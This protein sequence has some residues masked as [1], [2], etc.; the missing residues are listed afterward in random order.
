MKTMSVR[1]RAER[2]AAALR[3]RCANS[4][5]TAGFTLVELIVVIAILGI[6]AG[7]GT[8]AYSGYVKKANQAADNML[9]SAVN[10]SF[11]AACL[12]NGTDV[13]NVANA[14]LDMSGKSVAG[15]ASISGTGINAADVGQYSASF[16]KYFAGNETSEFRVIEALVF[17]AEKHVFVDMATAGE[18]TVSYGGGVVKL[19]SADIKA[20]GESTFITKVGVNDLL[21]QVDQVATFAGALTSTAM[22]QVFQSQEFMQ[23]AAEA[24]SM[25]LTGDTAADMAAFNAKLVELAGTD[26]DAQNKVLSNAAVMFAA[27][28]AASM[29]QSEIIDLLSGENARDTIIGNLSGNTGTALT[30]AA[31]AY[32]MYMAYAHDSGDSDKINN[33]DDPLAVMNAF[34]TDA[35]FK[36]YVASDKGKTDLNG[37]LS[38]LRMLDNSTED[39]AAVST[40]LVKGFNDPDL[41]N[42]FNQVLSDR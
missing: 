19:N 25:T 13:Q 9:L 42:L 18:V 31:L 35:D 6:L 21:D 32:G 34:D 1:N 37:Y 22:Q 27:H 41:V 40:V 2:I 20:L 39:S 38:A 8:V 15:V 33:V 4:T 23:Y 30:Q 10:T 16:V 28:N 12:E 3:E 26:P 7:V 29:P 14:A 36:S 17:D 24:M 11:A 5:R